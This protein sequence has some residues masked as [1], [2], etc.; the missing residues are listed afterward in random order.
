MK[1]SAEIDECLELNKQK[2]MR[3]EQLRQNFIKNRLK[4]KGKPLS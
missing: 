1:L 2:E 3:E 4:E